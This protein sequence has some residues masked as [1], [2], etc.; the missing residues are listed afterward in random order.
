M[1]KREEGPVQ[2]ILFGRGSVIQL[3]ANAVF[4][5]LGVSLVANAISDSWS[6]LIELSIGI[7]VVAMSVGYLALRYLETDRTIHFRGSLAY[8]EGANKIRKIPGYQLSGAIGANLEAASVQDE[9][10]KHQWNKTSDN[11]TPFDTG[12]RSDEAILLLNEA[13]EYWTI[14]QLS[15]H[16]QGYFG[17]PPFDAKLL[18]SYTRDNIPAALLSNRFLDLFTRPLTDR[19]LP[20][21]LTDRLQP[22]IAVEVVVR[23]RGKKVVLSS[24]SELGVYIPLNLV[25]PAKGT[26]D[27][28]QDGRLLIDTT[29]LR[30]AISLR[31]DDSLKGLPARFM[32]YYVEPGELEAEGVIG[33]GI[34]VV[35]L[36]VSGEV[37]IKIKPRALLSRRGWQYYMWVDSFLRSVEYGA[38]ISWFMDRINWTQIEAQLHAEEGWRRR[39]QLDASLRPPDHLPPSPPQ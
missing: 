7:L 13:L 15:T 37:S 11:A 2:R 14:S 33:I 38:N 27:R 35:D 21:N 20:S 23:R 10:L 19:A 30:L 5:A 22:T 36:G 31:Y 16:L 1:D 24:S 39:D 6:V 29:F 17:F 12:P 9:A 32:K 8:D 3:W 28:D 26:I 4:L 18:Q 25:L 34:G